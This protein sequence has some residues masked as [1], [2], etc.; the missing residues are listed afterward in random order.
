MF[1]LE[2]NIN[3]EGSETIVPILVVFLDEVVV[4]QIWPIMLKVKMHYNMCNQRLVCK[5]WLYGISPSN[6][7]CKVL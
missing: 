5:T 1:F 6:I 7:L 2:V 4:L 3:G